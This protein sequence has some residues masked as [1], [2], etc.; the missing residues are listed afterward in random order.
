MV[1]A[2]HSTFSEFGH[3]P[4]SA[5]RK[6]ILFIHIPKTAGTS[7]RNGAQRFLGEKQVL[8]DYGLEQS[9]TSGAV[10]NL[11]YQQNDIDRFKR[12]C[13]HKSVK[14]VC[15]HVHLQRYLP[16]FDLASVVTFLRDPLQR[17]ASDYYHFVRHHQFT[18]SL[19]EFAARP[20]HQNR[21][22]KMLD[23][24]DLEKL[25]FVGISEFYEKEL[26]RLNAVLG[27]DVPLLQQNMG[28][29]SLQERYEIPDRIERLIREN[30]RLD[31]EFYEQALVMASNKNERPLSESYFHGSCALSE[32]FMLQGWA[33]RIGSECP[34]KVR[35]LI[36]GTL[37]TEVLASDFRPGLRTEKRSGCAGFKLQL[38]RLRS[39]DKVRC[40]GGHPGV[41][42]KN[43]PIIV[44]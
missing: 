26:A 27:W 20:A 28:R 15:G 13:E 3:A 4:C 40:I 25:G 22:A 39:G 5:L 2:T 7:L 17:V 29:Q 36:N 42:L 33:A 11:V 31:Y 16:I 32:H 38:P 23:L 14:L 37:F 19:E 43:S 10:R 34:A 1:S 24:V 30:N 8:L 44:P 18:G 41:E 35:I 9:A 21:Q 12:H 6:P